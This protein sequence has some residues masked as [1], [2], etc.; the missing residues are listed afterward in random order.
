MANSEK[1]RIELAQLIKDV[2]QYKESDL[3][4]LFLELLESIEGVY[5]REWLELTKDRF[6]ERRGAGKQISLLIDAMKSGALPIV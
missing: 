2:A 1:Q 3:H 5:G 4:K 6:D